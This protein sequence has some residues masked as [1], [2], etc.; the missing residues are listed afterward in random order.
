MAQPMSSGVWLSDA[1]DINGAGG[2]P[3]Q[4]ELPEQVIA[5]SVWIEEGKHIANG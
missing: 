2:I 1:L 5:T 4:V 3:W